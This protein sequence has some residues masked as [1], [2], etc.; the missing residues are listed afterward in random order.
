MKEYNRARVYLDENYRSQEHFTV[1]ACAPRECCQSAVFLCRGERVA[2]IAGS[3]WAQPGSWCLRCSQ[4]G[5][6]P[7]HSCLPRGWPQGRETEPSMGLG[8]SCPSSLR[9]LGLG[10]RGHLEGSPSEAHSC[11]C[12]GAGEALWRS[13]PWPG[14]WSGGQTSQVP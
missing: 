11:R 8:E 14:C 6:L 7:P 10:H 1:S 9:V 13:R 2:C 12:T 5:G 3:L 4:C